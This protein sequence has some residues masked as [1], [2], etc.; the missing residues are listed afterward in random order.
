MQIFPQ[1]LNYELWNIVE[2]PYQKPTTSYTEWTLDEKTSANLNAK[3]MNALF[4]A[5][6]KNEFNR[7]STSTSAH[8]IWHTIEVTHEGTSKVKE[9]KIS[10]LV[11][12]FELFKMEEY[13]TISEM[14]TR[15][16]DITN[17]L[18]AL[19]KHY[20]Q[21]EMV[22]KVLRALT[23]EWENKTTVIEEAN[24]LL[25][26]TL[27]NLVGNLMAYEVQL[28]DRWENEQPKKKLLAFNA[29]SDTDTTDKETTNMCVMAQLNEVSNSN[30]QDEVLN[31]FNELFCEF[32]KE[33]IKNKFLR[34]EN[35]SLIDTNSNL[36]LETS[37]LNS[38]FSDLEKDISVLKNKYEYFLKNISK[39]KN[40]IYSHS[41]C[42][43]HSISLAKIY[44][45]KYKMIWVSKYLNLH[46]KENYISS[47]MNAS[48][49][50][51]YIY[52]NNWKPN[53]K[54]VWISKD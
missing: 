40:K 36:A 49:D 4:C 6:D 27:E 45:A 1:S 48:N 16:T 38:R 35:V 18:I 5:L 23:P 37:S 41:S 7:V 2:T 10:I 12:R 42:V 19:G 13:E 3:A 30:E 50:N 29:S 43:N 20:T 51:D 32:K 52:A 9:S 53:S 11:H 26:L 24:D 25:T 28:Q 31:A 46:E 54:W 39:F 22:R 14:I 21:V 34:K 15:F 8:Q 47:Y 17:S 44:H 33:K